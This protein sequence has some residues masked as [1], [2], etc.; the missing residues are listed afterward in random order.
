MGII[1]YFIPES[2]LSY[3][4]YIIETNKFNVIPVLATTRSTGEKINH[5][6]LWCVNLDN[7]Y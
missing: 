5:D 2:M 7:A 3:F 1:W 6:P 4:K